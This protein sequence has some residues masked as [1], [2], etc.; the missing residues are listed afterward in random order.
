MMAPR[1]GRVVV[2][3]FAGAGI[4]AGG[5]IVALLMGKVIPV[6]IPARYLATFG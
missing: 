3:G 5:L 1:R 4:V 6:D 2:A